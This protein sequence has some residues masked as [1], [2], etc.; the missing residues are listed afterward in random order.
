MSVLVGMLMSVTMAMSM[1]MAMSVRIA[2]S[3]RMAV[4]MGMV[5]AMARFVSLDMIVSM[6]MVLCKPV[7][8]PDTMRMVLSVAIAFVVSGLFFTLLLI[9]L[10]HCRGESFDLLYLYRKFFHV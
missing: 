2:M 1:R 10:F 7:D 6:G 3:V 5:V 9:E 4:L 8:M